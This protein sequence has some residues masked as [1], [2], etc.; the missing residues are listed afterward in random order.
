MLIKKFTT[1][2]MIPVE[3]KKIPGVSITQKLF[4]KDIEFHHIASLSVCKISQNLH[5]CFFN[6]S[7][8]CRFCRSNKIGGNPILFSHRFLFGKCQK[9]TPNSSFSFP[10]KAKPNPCKPKWIMDQTTWSCINQIWN[11][12]YTDVNR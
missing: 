10:L 4:L 9:T 1:M 2:K 12:H 11:K 7:N 3:K 8:L 5:R 6:Q